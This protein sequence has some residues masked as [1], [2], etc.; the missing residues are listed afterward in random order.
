MTLWEEHLLPLLTRKEAA[1]LA[2]TCKA[3]RGVLCEHFKPP[4]RST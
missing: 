3:L 2:C 4:A 1:R